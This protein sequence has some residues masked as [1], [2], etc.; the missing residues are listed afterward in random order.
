MLLVWSN[1]YLHFNIKIY[2]FSFWCLTN[3]YRVNWGLVALYS[4]EIYAHLILIFPR[5][6]LN[7]FKILLPCKPQSP[8]ALRL[9]SHKTW[10][11]RCE[12]QNLLILL[13]SELF[14]MYTCWIL[15]M[16]ERSLQVVIFCRRQ[17]ITYCVNYHNYLK[18]SLKHDCAKTLGFMTVTL[19]TWNQDFF[20]KPV[21]TKVA[22][23]IPN[24][25]W[26]IWHL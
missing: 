18:F 15:V 25:Y 20:C 3:P 10:D 23:L 21:I 24:K 9:A 8:G 5:S 13:F 22:Y 26:F 1:W 7:K 11:V 19:T 2:C 14:R 4:Q 12:C 6:Y 17:S 16:P